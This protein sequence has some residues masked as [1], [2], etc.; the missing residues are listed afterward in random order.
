MVLWDFADDDVDRLE[1]VIRRPKLAFNER[2]CETH[3]ASVSWYCGGSKEQG[4][5]NGHVKKYPTGHSTVAKMRTALTG[6]KA[7]RDLVN[8]AQK[9]NYFKPPSSNTRQRRLLRLPT[10]KIEQPSV[11][12]RT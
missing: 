8:V 12:V 4:V 9:S 5:N 6:P 11:R 1:I 10:V 7:L 2:N 3:V